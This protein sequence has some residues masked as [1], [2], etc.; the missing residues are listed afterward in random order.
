[1][2]KLFSG[3]R[4]VPTWLAALQA[5][6]QSGGDDQNFLLEIADPLSMTT[7]DSE[8]IACVDEALRTHSDISVKTVAA[9]IFP[10]AMYRRYGRPAFYTEFSKRMKRAKKEGTWGT[11]ALRMIERRGKKKNEVVN[12]LEQVIEKL[13]RATTGG[14]AFHDIYEMGVAEPSED[15]DLNEEN[16]YG[17]ELPTFDAA[18]DGRK[19]SNM[20][21]LSH[22]SF[23][24]VD[25]ERVDLTVMYRSHYYCQRA[26][27]NLIGLAQLL[28]FVAKESQL[29][30]GTL[31]CLSTHAHLDSSS[32]GK[33]AEFKAVVQTLEKVGATA[34]SMV[35]KLVPPRKG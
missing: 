8:M 26:L 14:Q 12:P 35:E 27:G 13:V 18:R 19:V 34:P 20:P 21:C 31:T 15:F 16:Y 6:R 4:V 2:A 23:K 29:K 10:I 3:E 11:Y 7:Q 17:C 33:A 22:L 32:W 25:K 24:L 5:L 9:T 1:M 30:V 28:S